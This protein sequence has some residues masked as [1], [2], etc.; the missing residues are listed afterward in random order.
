MLTCTEINRSQNKQ[1]I[2]SCH[3]PHITPISIRQSAIKTQKPKPSFP[4][5]FTSIQPLDSNSR[6]TQG[7]EMHTKLLSL[8]K[9]LLIGG[10][11]VEEVAWEKER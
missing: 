8:F 2:Y 3:L 9:L 10:E 7:S 11:V 1:I 4:P 5:F 6:A